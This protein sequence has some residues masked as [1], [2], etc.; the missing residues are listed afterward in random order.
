M[1]YILGVGHGQS[2]CLAH[3]HEGFSFKIGERRHFLFK[4]EEHN[5]DGMVLKAQGDQDGTPQPMVEQDLLDMRFNTIMVR[6]RLTGIGIRLLDSDEVQAI[7]GG[8]VCYFPARLVVKTN[9]MEGFQT[10]CCFVQG[11]EADEG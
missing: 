2:N 9:G 4:A 11:K 1:R 8:D 6:Y 3:I 7:C 10:P 5:P